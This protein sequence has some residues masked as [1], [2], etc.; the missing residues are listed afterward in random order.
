MVDSQLRVEA[1]EGN[2]AMLSCRA[3]GLPQPTYEFYK[4]GIA[5]WPGRATGVASTVSK[6]CLSAFDN[7][8]QL[9]TRTW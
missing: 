8:T 4:V 6:F 2:E 3:D 7:T 1:L 5:T 9:A